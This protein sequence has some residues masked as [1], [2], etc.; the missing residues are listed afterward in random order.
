MDELARWLGEQLDADLPYAAA[1]H[2]AGCDMY[3]HL[4]V[5][6][7]SS[8]AAIAMYH[9]APGAVCSCDGPTRIRREI[10]AKQ[11]LLTDYAKEARLIERGYQSG[12]TDGG[13]AVRE[14]LIKTW[15]A[16][17]EQR[18]GYREDWRP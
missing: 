18:P 5:S 13:Q 17:Y 10:E 15:A 6:V 7:A 9:E 4:G 14:H 2:I 1:W 12:W 8:V 16:I 11:R 3:G